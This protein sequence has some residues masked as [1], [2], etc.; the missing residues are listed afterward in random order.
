M[1]IQINDKEIEEAV[2]CY[3]EKQGINTKAQKVSID[4]ISGRG[5]TGPRVDINLEPKITIEESIN[6]ETEEVDLPFGS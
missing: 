1:K 3:L 6:R 2:I 4:V 5:D